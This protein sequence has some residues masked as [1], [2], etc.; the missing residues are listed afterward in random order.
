MHQHRRLAHLVD[1]GAESGRALLELDEKVDPF[2]FPVGADEIEHQ[3]RPIGIAGLGE[4]VEL[5]LGQEM[6][7]FHFIVGMTKS[8][9]ARVPDGQRAVTVLVLV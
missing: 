5:V 9:P 3:R 4:A 2:R 6:L 7:S 1:L 8:A